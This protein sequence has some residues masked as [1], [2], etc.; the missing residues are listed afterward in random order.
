MANPFKITKAPWASFILNVA[1]LEGLSQALE[2]L[3]T[4]TN[5][6]IVA[7]NTTLQD[8]LELYNEKLE[9][10][11]DFATEVHEDAEVAYEEKTEKWQEG[12]RGAASLEW[13]GEWRGLL[14]EVGG[15]IEIEEIEEISFDLPDLS[16]PDS[17]P[18]C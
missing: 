15:P 2:T 7:L 3:V 1:E 16:L 4:E 14:D 6:K 13:I 18:N 10:V 5:A 9:E 8:A 11:R 12:E 17:E